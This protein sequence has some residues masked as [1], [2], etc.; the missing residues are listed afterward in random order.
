MSTNEPTTVLIVDDE[1]EVCS[2]YRL[3]CKDE[4]YRLRVAEGG[5]EALLKVDDDVDVVLLDR[6]MPE[7]PGDE[8]LEFIR[9]WNFSCR[10]VMV[11]A[12]DPDESVLEMGFD[13]YLCKP[14]S[15]EKL[16]NEIERQALFDRYQTL[17]E[18]YQTAMT[19]H[20]LLASQDDIYA[21]EIETLVERREELKRE[22]E[23]TVEAFDNEAVKETLAA[24]HQRN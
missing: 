9:E 4:K 5:A 19:K 16:V 13:G 20:A 3:Y 17:F 2:T 15:K 18:K 7:M 23:Q 22:L 8:V 11:T 21:E 12:V 6:R 14:V 24:L 10:V 1:E